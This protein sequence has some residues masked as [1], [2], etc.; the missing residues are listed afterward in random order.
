MTFK[1]RTVRDLDP[2]GKRVLVRVDFNVPLDKGA[3]ADDTRI[4]AALPTI[5][6]LQARGGALALVSHL[7]RPKGRD[8]KLSLAPVAKRLGELLGREVPLM[9]DAVGQEIARRVRA[10]EPGE[11]VLL[12]N[13]RFHREEEENDPAFAK[14]LATGFDAYVNDA[15]GTAHRAHASTEGI[16]RILP[17]YAGLLLEKELT[18]LGGILEHPAKPF[19]AII[20]GAKVST[21]MDV[22]RSLVPRVD[23][24]AI[25]GGMANTFLLAAGHGVGRSLVEPEK[26][27]EARRVTDEVEGNGKTLLIPVDVVCAPSADEDGAAAAG[28]FG[29]DDVP[30]G[31]AI[32]DVGPRT[33][34][35]YAGVIGRA[36][37]I[38]WNG[39]LGVF[40]VPAFAN[41]TR[42]V[43][44][45]LASSGAVTVVGGGESVQAVE[46][47]GLAEKMTHVS[48]GGGASLEL[49]EGKT[50]PGVAAIPDR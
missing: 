38:F 37:T 44:E 18:A 39:P 20:G 26:E 17:A 40:E 13:V 14:A 23:A 28:V 49:I 34:E 16:A 22:L 10:L 36:K 48:T 21:K 1:K 30:S 32:V 9:P 42:R 31:E 4:R 27:T 2:K 46:E 3:V 8:A 41:G 5:R 24:L 35:R 25:G 11:V 12:E 19:L 47:A 15:F 43:A 33:L 7:G 29:V 6:L 45:L 50:L